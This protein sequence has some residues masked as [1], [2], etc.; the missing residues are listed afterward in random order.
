[1]NIMFISTC[2]F[3]TGFLNLLLAKVERDGELS[4]WAYII[5]A[6][7]FT[8]IVGGLSWCFYRALSATNKDAPEQLPDDV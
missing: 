6:F 1:M 8:I 5:L 4:N 3:G 7:M 2:L